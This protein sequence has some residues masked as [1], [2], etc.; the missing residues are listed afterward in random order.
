VHRGAGQARI[1]RIGKLHFGIDA[2][3]EAAFE[4]GRRTQRRDLKAARLK[5]GAQGRGPGLQPGCQFV[6]GPGF[7]FGCGCGQDRVDR[8][9]PDGR[10]I[11]PPVQAQVP[12]PLRFAG[13]LPPHA[14]QHQAPGEPQAQLAQQGL[15]PLFLGAADRCVQPLGRLCAAVGE[16]RLGAH[17]DR[18][19][20]GGNP[21]VVAAHGRVEILNR[22][23]GVDS[24]ARRLPGVH[25]QAFAVPTPWL[26]TPRRTGTDARARRSIRPLRWPWL[27]QRRPVWPP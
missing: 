4:R 23:H 3:H 27:A 18:E 16:G 24:V 12:A 2:H 19:A 5:R 10:A 26:V 6:P 15:R 7:Q 17:P 14:A 21:A 13:V 20:Q 22:R 1:R 25:G 9:A 8:P 11:A